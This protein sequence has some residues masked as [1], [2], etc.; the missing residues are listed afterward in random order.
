ML[1]AATA[2]GTNPNVT[3]AI[4]NKPQLDVRI[5]RRSATIA[6]AALSSP[7]GS[8]DVTT[9]EHVAFVGSGSHGNA[10][11]VQWRNQN[12]EAYVRDKKLRQ[13]LERGKLHP[14]QILFVE[15]IEQFFLD[16]DT[17][18]LR[19]GRLEI[20]RLLYPRRL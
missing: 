13:A 18:E 5:D 12:R 19:S 17:G 9:S 3:L 1:A 15:I 7:K 16:R 20:R 8:V 2:N 6:S 11:L 10:W 14:G 4:P